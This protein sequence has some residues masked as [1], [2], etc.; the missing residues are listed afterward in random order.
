MISDAEL[1]K[2]VMERYPEQP[3]PFIIE[4]FTVLKAGLIQAN[5]KLAA[6]DMEEPV[7]EQVIIEEPMP[8]AAEAAPSAAPKKKFTK[9][10]LVVRPEEAIGDDVVQCCLCGRGFQNLTAKHLLSHGISVDEY[11][12][13]C[14]YVPEQKLICKNLLEKLQENV[15]KA[16]RSREQKLSGEHLKKAKAGHPFGCP[17]SWRM[18]GGEAGKRGGPSAV[19]S[20]IALVRA[21]PLRDA[22]LVCVP[23]VAPDFNKRF[24]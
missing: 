17:V 7:C 8:E 21:A 24:F 10:S 9:R 6:M 18:L 3:T 19:G 11:K 13:L 2:L 23:F 5:N 16:Q 20:G 1:L 14:G 22:R 4:Q 12:K 15:Q